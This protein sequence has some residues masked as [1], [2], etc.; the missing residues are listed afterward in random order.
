MLGSSNKPCFLLITIL[1]HSQISQSKE[2]RGVWHQL[3]LSREHKN[4]ENKDRTFSR[5]EISPP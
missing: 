4:K 2:E 5:A 1:K 3:L